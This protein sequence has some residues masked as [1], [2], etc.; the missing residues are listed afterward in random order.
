M[1]G[2]RAIAVIG[3][4]LCLVGT[5]CADTSNRADVYEEDFA[6]QGLPSERTHAFR[7]TVFEY[8]REVGGF[9]EIF[10]IDGARNTHTN[11]YFQ[12]DA[13]EY[14]GA[15]RLQNEQFPVA[16]R[17]P[18]GPLLLSASLVDGGRQVA[19]VLV[20]PGGAAAA[21]NMAVSM[22]RTDD[23]PARECSVPPYPTD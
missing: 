16:V 23:A 6:L 5:A 12:A 9:L 15:G 7:L 1:Y 22:V 4:V 13:C 10:A 18:D 19:A 17:G 2:Q 20:E 14:F 3:A 11:P 8:E 21:E